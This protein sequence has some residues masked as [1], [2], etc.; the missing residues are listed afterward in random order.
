MKTR[1]GFVSNSSS[2][3]FVVP[4]AALT[5]AQ[6]AMIKDHIEFAQTLQKLD[7]E[8]QELQWYADE[9][10]EW[11]IEEGTNEKG[12]KV[13]TGD[14]SMDNFDMQHFMGQIGVPAGLVEWEHGHW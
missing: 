10:D 11:K 12:E 8:N 4:L 5:A 2:S 3:S 1:N 6:I 9:G 14:T 7:P 13:L